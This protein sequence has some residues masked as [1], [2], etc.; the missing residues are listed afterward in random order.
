MSDAAAAAAPE[1]GSAATYLPPA[2]PTSPLLSLDECEDRIEHLLRLCA[3]VCA[4]LSEVSSES[5]VQVG[6]DV[7]EFHASL[8]LVYASILSHIRT[9][10]GEVHLHSAAGGSSS[11]GSSGTGSSSSA[12][13]A[14][15]AREY[16]RNVYL[17]AQQMA[18]MLEGL[19]IAKERI[20]QAQ[21]AQTQMMQQPAQDAVQSAQR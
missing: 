20:Q 9:H 15:A 6:A 17:D 12:A 8:R 10:S 3:S 16:R 18:V 14:T 7:R 4:G 5:P 1:S 11:G 19:D 21:E 13:A 2:L